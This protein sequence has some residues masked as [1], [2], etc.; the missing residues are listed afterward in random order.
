MQMN[1]TWP[2]APSTIASVA[3]TA[4]GTEY[5]A[6]IVC[7]YYNPNTGA[8]PP[9]PPSGAGTNSEEV[10]LSNLAAGTAGTFDIDINI[11]PGPGG[12]AFLVIGAWP[13]MWGTT[14]IAAQE[15]SFMHRIPQC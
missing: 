5:G 12:G 8:L 3:L 10:D 6:T 2:T 14:V 1:V 7:F 4:Q 9:S 11:G 13:E 15:Q